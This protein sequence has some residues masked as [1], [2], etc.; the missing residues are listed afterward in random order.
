MVCYILP[1]TV[2]LISALRRKALGKHDIE[3]FW[4]NLMFLGAALFGVIDHWWN[5]ELFLIGAN[6]MMDL[7]LGATITAGV[8]ISWKFIV[9]KNTM[10]NTTVTMGR[11]TGTHK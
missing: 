10:V 3:G 11:L 5:G 2:G 7:G 6:W 8:L 9:Y 1:L 4:L